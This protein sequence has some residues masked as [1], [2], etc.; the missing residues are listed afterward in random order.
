VVSD[1]V[2]FASST[3][4]DINAGFGTSVIEVATFGLDADIA[5]VGGTAFGE[6]TIT[7]SDFG[8]LNV[9]TTAPGTNWWTISNSGATVNPVAYPYG[10]FGSELLLN[11]GLGNNITS[12]LLSGSTT[13]DF[14]LGGNGVAAMNP[15]P[16]P[17]SLLAVAGC[18]G[19]A[20]LIRRRRKAA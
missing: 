3:F 14:T 9:S 12:Q 4:A 13:G 1:S 6:T 2:N 11:Y 16:E 20:G 18:L 17:G 8:V 15:V 19:L 5:A 10:S 7:A